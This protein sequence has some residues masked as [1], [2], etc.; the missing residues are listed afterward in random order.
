MKKNTKFFLFILVVVVLAL[1]FAV[2][3]VS[4][5]QSV[6]NQNTTVNGNNVVRQKDKNGFDI[7]SQSDIAKHSNKDSCWMSIDGSV[8]DV[9]VFIPTHP[10]G[11]A[12]LNG[13]GKDASEMFHSVSAHSV[14]N[15]MANLLAKFKIGVTTSS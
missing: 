11:K 6:N 9:T 10:G 3:K 7:F 13:C 8:Y 15:Q 4:S 5:K 12:I 14:G 2:Y 1:V